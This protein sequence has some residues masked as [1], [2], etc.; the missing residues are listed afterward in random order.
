VYERLPERLRRELQVAPAPATRSV[1]GELA[2]RAGRPDLSYGSW[3][4]AACAA[5]CADDFERALAFVDRGAQAIAGRGLRAVEVQYL[6]PRSYVLAR[7][8]RLG[9]GRSSTTRRA[10]RSGGRGSARS[11]RARARAPGAHG[12]VWR[13]SSSS[14]T[15]MWPGAWVIISSGLLWVATAC[16]VTP[17]AQNTGTSP[18]RISTASP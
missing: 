5:A 18:S 12:T 3:I 1:S 13:I 4:N 9:C 15:N 17:H 8:G 11:R 14:V 10:S 16:G 6:A 7:M 2:E